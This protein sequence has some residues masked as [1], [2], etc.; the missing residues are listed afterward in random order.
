[1]IEHCSRSSKTINWS[2]DSFQINYV[3][4]M[5][6]HMSLQYGHGILVSAYHVLTAVNWPYCECYKRCGLGKTRL[7]HP[8]LP[9]DSLPYSTR[10]Y[11]RSVNHMTTKWKEVDPIPWV[12]GI[13]RP[14][15]KYEHLCWRYK[16]HKVPARLTMDKTVKQPVQNIGHVASAFVLLCIQKAVIPL[17][18][19]ASQKIRR[20]V[21]QKSGSSLHFAC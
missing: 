16:R 2:E 4:L 5:S 18:A 14:L 9:F 13:C 21:Y 11:V 10:S 20:P 15:S 1:M 3:S 6:W 19:I 17:H 7:R 12:W 8:S